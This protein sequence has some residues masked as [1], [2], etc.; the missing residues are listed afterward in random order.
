[1]RL[2]VPF[3]GY[4]LAIVGFLLPSVVFVAFLP[5]LI[6]TEPVKARLMAELRDW[7]GGDVNVTG[8]VSIESFFSLTVDMRNVEL[9]GVKGVTSITSVKAG[10]MVARIAWGDLLL[11][12]LDFD[13]IRIFDAD[14]YA[15]GGNTAEIGAAV[16]S[17]LGGAQQN[18]FAGLAIADSVIIFEGDAPLASRRLQITRATTNLR[19]SDGRIS[20]SG[21]LRWKGEPISFRLTTNL[22]PVA[23]PAAPVPMIVNV[24]S[25]LLSGG[26]NGETSLKGALNAAGHLSLT[27]PDMPGLAKWSGWPLEDNMAGAV[28]LTGSVNLAPDWVS[29]QAAAFAVAGQQ[30][31][32]DL[33]LKFAADPV[34]LEGALA[35]EDLDFGPLWTETLGE[36]LPGPE[37]P[38]MARRLMKSVN[39]DLRVSAEALRWN[40]AI[41]RPAAFTLTSNAGHVSAEIADL[42]L[43]DG[44]VLGHVDADLTREPARVRARLTAENIDT[45][46]ILGA[47]SQRPWLSGRADARLEV[48]AEGRGGKQLLE[49]ATAQARI[50][51]ANGGSI[52]FDI[53]QLA[54]ASPAQGGNGWSELGFAAAEFEEL[55][56]Q[57]TLK[58]GEL[59]CDDLNLRSAGEITRGQGSVDLARQQVD[60]RFTVRKSA[61]GTGRGEAAS[62]VA[63][64]PSEASLSIQGPWA[65]PTFRAGERSGALPVDR[66]AA[67]RNDWFGFATRIGSAAFAGSE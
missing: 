5:S 14:I 16:L 56:L 51:F 45:A 11:G 42:G 8:A 55:R 40:H 34:Q 41:A 7:T 21:K 13:K 9:G 17:A 35:F 3:F 31:S 57:L 49:S 53:P 54:N 1:M 23:A 63:D 48:E 18:P 20:L 46:L 24:D 61:G 30:A 67:R 64:V 33:M 59:R 29:L 60:W 19:K 15:K 28:H 50:S 44:S 25:R 36:R 6:N 65:R 66:P 27:T 47:V 37:T 58:G 2:K 10:R 32:G 38:S 26:F 52:P 62:G 12:N 22:P 39:M 43:F 4:V